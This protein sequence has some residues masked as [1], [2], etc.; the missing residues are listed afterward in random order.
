MR[1]RR[2][3]ESRHQTQLSPLTE[4]GVLLGAL[5]GLV[6]ELGLDIEL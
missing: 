4:V 3:L 2:G 5:R 1:R 6:P